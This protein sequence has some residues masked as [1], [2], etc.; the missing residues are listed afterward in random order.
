[1]KTKVRL[2]KVNGT[3]SLEFS[4]KCRV[5]K[6]KWHHF[7]CKY[8]RLFVSRIPLYWNVSVTPPPV[9]VGVK[10]NDTCCR[11]MT[12]GQPGNPY[13]VVKLS[14]VDLLVLSSL[15]QLLFLL[16]ILIILATKQATLIWRS[17]ILSL[18]FQ[19]VFPGPTFHS[20]VGSTSFGQQTFGSKTFD[21]PTFGWYSVRSRMPWPCP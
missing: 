21:Q 8:L 7:C 6:M 5:D 3:F 15:D 18:P 10:F 12:S 19:I 1:M 13:S 17:F 14:T 11:R 16:K 4:I 9:K 20:L 2:V